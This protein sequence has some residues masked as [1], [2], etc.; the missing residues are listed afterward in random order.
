MHSVARFLVLLKKHN[1]MNLLLHEYYNT[2]VSSLIYT[3]LFIFIRN[4]QS[5][6][7]T[8]PLS[9][10]LSSNMNQ[11]TTLQSLARIFKETVNTLI[12]KRNETASSIIER[13]TLLLLD[14]YFGIRQKLTPD[15]YSSKERREGGRKQEAK[16]KRKKRREGSIW[17]VSIGQISINLAGAR[18]RHRPS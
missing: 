6:V 11:K 7:S 15:E 12:A 17:R 1:P 10:H 5:C 16:M 13:R 2:C 18:V 14:R 3:I 4:C 9:I 8:K